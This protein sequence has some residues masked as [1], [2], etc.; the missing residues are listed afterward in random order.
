M[1]GIYKSG[2]IGEPESHYSFILVFGFSVK[3]RYL[4]FNFIGLASAFIR[5]LLCI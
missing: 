5:M 2:S 1:V 4:D 3:Y